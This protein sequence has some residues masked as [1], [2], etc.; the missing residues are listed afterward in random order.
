VSRDALERPE[1]VRAETGIGA[2]E[3]VACEVDVLPT[4]PCEVGEKF[5]RHRVATASDNAEGAA[6]RDGVPHHNCCCYP[7]QGR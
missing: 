7:R 2:L 4:E 6:E 3:I 1:S 5:V